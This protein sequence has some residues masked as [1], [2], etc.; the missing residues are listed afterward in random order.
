MQEITA[1][2]LLS[3]KNSFNV[4][5][6]CTHGCIY[7]DSRSE[8]YGKTYTFEDVEIKTNAV[9]LLEKEL[10][11]KRKKSML[12]TGAMTD[13]YLPLEKELE[14]TRKCLE[15]ILKHEFGIALLTKS[16]LILRDIDLLQ[17]LHAQT[18]CVVQMTLTTFDEA[19]CKTLE[20]HVCT[21]KRRF[22]VLQELQKAGI[23]TIVWLTPTLPFLNDNEE[24]LLGLLDYCK[25]AGVKGIVTFGFGMT[26][27]FG[28][29][30]YFYKQLDAHFPGLKQ[31]YMRR[32]GSAYGL[33]SPQSATLSQKT[34]RFCAKNDILYG[35]KNVFPFVWDFPQH[36]TQLSFFNE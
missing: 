11:K 27:R 10:S 23:P 20:P 19:L 13:P 6:G 7:C 9:E 15:T 25:Q 18:K 21:S 3:A 14:I 28:N 24:N 30:E 33:R 32:F 34:R 4:Y 17:R 5:R 16:D 35:E 12:V 22:E 29:R 31:T 8:I 1:K 36:E 26:L 2:T